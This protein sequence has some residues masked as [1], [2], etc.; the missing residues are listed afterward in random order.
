[1]AIIPERGAVRLWRDPDARKKTL[2]MF[3]SPQAEVS[4]DGAAEPRQ[5]SHALSLTLW[6]KKSCGGIATVT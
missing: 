5:S 6:N 1:M 3:P 4:A 2:C